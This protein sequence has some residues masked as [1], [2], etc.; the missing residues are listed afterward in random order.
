MLEDVELHAGKRDPDQIEYD[1]LKDDI[2]QNGVRGN[3]HANTAIPL[4]RDSRNHMEGGVSDQVV[5]MEPKKYKKFSIIVNINSYQ[6]LNTPYPNQVANVSGDLEDKGIPHI[7]DAKSIMEVTTND[8]PIRSES[9]DEGLEKEMVPYTLIENSS[10]YQYS[11]DTLSYHFF[12]NARPL[13]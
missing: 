8:D 11:D 4:C 3:I 2:S 1:E 12:Q 6:S 5:K 7:I 9:K 10:P 13:R